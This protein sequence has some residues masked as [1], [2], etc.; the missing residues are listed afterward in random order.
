MGMAREILFRGK[1]ISDGKWVEGDL[2]RCIVVGKTYICKIEEN[3]STTTHEIDSATVCQYTGYADLRKKKVFEHDIVFCENNGCH[4][5]VEFENG[6]F[7]I[8]WEAKK[9]NL[10][11]DIHFW[12]KERRMYVVNNIFDN[13]ELMEEGSQ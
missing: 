6:K 9:E 13:P 3:I 5:H 12:F 11:N 4:G 7:E 2:N 10:R 1:R 8:K